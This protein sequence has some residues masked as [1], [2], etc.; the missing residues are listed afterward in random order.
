M[1]VCPGTSAESAGM[2]AVCGSEVSVVMRSSPDT[3][4]ASGSVVQALLADATAAAVSTATT[5]AR[6]FITF[7][8]CL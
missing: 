5:R 1:T 7:I 6:V 8:T 3:S 4:T 2:S